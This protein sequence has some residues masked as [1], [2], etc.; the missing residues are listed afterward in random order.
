EAA[1]AAL[2]A[3]EDELS[4]PGAWATP[5]AAARSTARH[6]EAKRAVDELYERWGAVAG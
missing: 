4:D 6:A 1:E 3:I 2:A 5:D